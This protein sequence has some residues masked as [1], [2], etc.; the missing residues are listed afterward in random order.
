SIRVEE[1]MLVK[2]LGPASGSGKTLA[3]ARRALADVTG[4]IAEL[5]P[6]DQAAPSCYA[7]KGPSLRTR[8]LASPA[9]GCHPLVRPNYGYFNKAL[10]RTAP[11]VVIIAP[12]ARCFDTADRNN[13]E[14]NSTSPA[15]C[16]ANRALIE[17]LD[18]AAIRAWL[19]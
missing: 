19:R 10:P 18:I 8:F 16:R 17:T 13:R 9:P 14:A 7:A 6:T 3:D 12:V 11:Q 15:G 4:W 1:T 2:D 5:S